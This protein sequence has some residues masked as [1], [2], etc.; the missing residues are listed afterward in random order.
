MTQINICDWC[1]RDLDPIGKIPRYIKVILKYKE[2]TKDWLE[3][4]RE[5]EI[6][7]NCFDRLINNLK[8]NDTTR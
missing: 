8:D 3:K 1:K 7:E 4:Y 6:C 2:N 5:V